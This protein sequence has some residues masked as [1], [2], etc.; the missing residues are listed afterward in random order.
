MKTNKLCV[1]LL[2]FTGFLFAGE[3]LASTD[4]KKK[5]SPNILWI[6][7]DDQRPDALGCFNRATTG[8]SE[9]PLGHVESPYIDK[10]AEE[11][12]LFVN[13][14][15]NSP[16]CGPSRGS[17]KTGRYP[18][19]NGHYAFEVT[20]QNP[21][22]I[23]PAISQILRKEGY[24]TAIFGKTGAYIYKWG[25]GQDFHDAG[26]YDFT[27]HFKHDLQKNG[28]GDIF[29]APSAKV[30][31]GV[32]TMEESIVYPNGSV[33]TYPVKRNPGGLSQKEQKIMQEIDSSYEI[34]RAPHRNSTLIFGGENPH[35][36]QKTIDGSI[37]HEFKNYL[38]NPGK[39]YTT[40]YGKKAS[41]ANPEKPLL[42]NLSF[43]LP[44]TPVLPPKKVRD[45]FKQ[46]SY[47]A[48]EYSDEDLASLPPQLQRLYKTC[49]WTPWS[50][51]EKQQAMQDYYAF[52]A[53]GDA[54]I[55]DAVKAFKTYCAKQGQ[56]YLIIFTV[57]DHSWHLGEQGIEAKFG[58]YKH[59][60]HNAA[61]VV[62]SDKNKFPPGEVSELMVEYVDFAPT[63]LKAGGVNINAPEYDYLDG[64]DLYETLV[65]GESPR[66]YI[67]GEMNL[68]IGHRAYM[69]T[70][71]FAFS[72][73]TRQTKGY[74]K[75]PFLNDNILWALICDPE[76][77]DLA[78]FDLR[79]DPSER[80]NV[81]TN[82]EYQELAAW[83]RDKL[84]RIVLGDGR[85]E[86]DWSQANSY[87]ISSFAGGADDKK[88]DIPPVLI[89]SAGNL[90]P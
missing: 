16:A 42:V 26:L 31:D 43:H 6:I 76:E 58:P 78:L 61:I 21:D 52:C 51:E 2:F 32:R 28:V 1:F 71:N 84:G 83:F 87:N 75:A 65:N 59:S 90:S 38:E 77:A 60:I 45:H 17:M 80:K 20:H 63:I 46:F 36:A 48:P 79:V 18:F 25:P 12:V 49:L 66:E 4:I 13:A 40:S 62:S 15:C 82:P 41:G 33:H 89:P 10:L 72:M 53:H 86:C 19:R 68:V 50:D 70:D 56:E 54:L 30:I 11:G 9:S 47:K 55:G 34:L 57:G 74:E 27:V 7:T 37:V 29:Y 85:I 8:K 39:S 23:K 35:P 3:N 73:R 88:L 5:E 64:Y 44:H 14:F 81:A 24:A 69:R 22:F 67:L